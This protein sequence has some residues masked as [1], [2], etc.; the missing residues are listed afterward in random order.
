MILKPI[1]LGQNSLTAQELTEDKKNCKKYGPCGVG[2][3][4]LYLNSF[5]IDRRYY[6]PLADVTRVFKRVAMSKGGFNGKGMFASIPY[7][8]VVY[9]GGKE[10]QCNFK[11]EENVDRML[12]YIG[13]V[14]PD[15]KLHSEEAEKRLLEKEK[16]RAARR[17]PELPEAAEAELNRLDRAYRYLN[18]EPE[19]FLNLSETARRKR[20]FEKS[21]PTYKWVAAA[22]FTLGACSLVYGIYALL[23]HADFAIYFTLFGMAAIFL[24]SSAGIFPTSR[25]NR[26]YIMRRAEM[27]REAVAEYVKGYGGKD[28][29]LPVYYAHPIVLKRMMDAIREGRA[30]D[31]DSALEIVKTDLK[32]LNADVEVEQEE[33]DEVVAIKVLFLNE[34]YR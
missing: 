19:L 28:F 23:H 31:S 16:A 29:P 25:N 17:I 26:R 24:F 15:I 13:R 2:E 9:D 27:A 1:Q 18:R 32:A 20:A 3:K 7:L 8:V 34:N 10:K 5:Y 30:A 12:L 33:Y 21:S 4:A 22:I 11:Y 6:V 14:R